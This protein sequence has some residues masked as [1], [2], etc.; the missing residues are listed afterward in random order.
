[1]SRYA[2]ADEERTRAGARVR[3]WTQSGLLEAAQGA[4]IEAGLR[5]DLKR[6]NRYLRIALF[7]FGTI[8][9]WAAFGFWLVAFSLRHDSVVAGSAIVAGIVCYT[10]AECLVL[11]FE[12]YRFGVEEAFAVSSVALLA[13]GA[14]FLTS[15]GSH[16]GDAPMLVAL[17]TAAIASAVVYLRFGYLYAALAAVACAASV[18]FFLGLPDAGARIISTCVLL[19]VFMMM[20]TLHRRYGE[21]FPGDD[22][23]RLESVAWLGTYAVLNLYLSLPSAIWFYRSRP[24]VPSVFYWATYAAIWLLPAVGLAL[25]IRDKHRSMLWANIVMAV[26]TLATNKPYLRWERHTWDPILLGVLLAGTAIAIRRWLT[27][28]PG[29]QRGGFTPKSLVASADRQAL[30]VLSTVAGAAQPL[31]ARTPAETTFEPDRG[32]RSGGGG[33]GAEF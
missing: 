14:G 33:G 3:E 18:A 9:V 29:G 24:D 11:Q 25:A 12:L 21:D 2:T 26:A 13:G 27:R 30:G 4:A 31:A 15:T 17:L 1:M 16:Y 23:G 10:L 7:I 8:I 6:T 5:A 20:R 32:G 19:A 28:G 22:Y